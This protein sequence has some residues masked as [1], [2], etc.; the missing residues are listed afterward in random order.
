M[1][2][3]SSA[4]DWVR[5]LGLARHPEGGWYRETYRA[6]EHV[7]GDHLPGRFGGSR[8]LSTAIYFLV[9]SPEF[10]AL[11]RIASDEVWHFHAGSP[12]VVAVI[13]ADGGT[14]EHRLGL[15][16]SRRE[17][18]QAVVAAGSWFGA[19]VDAPDG[20]TLVS[21]TVAPGFDFQDF[22]LGTRAALLARYPQHRALIERL[23]R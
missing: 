23:T 21:C 13:R 15:D 4:G 19:Y 11:H 16:T 5:A 12:L 14:E 17:R 1:A 10:S 7:A 8:A 6:A 3:R 18:P 22:E 20:W 9:E 2:E